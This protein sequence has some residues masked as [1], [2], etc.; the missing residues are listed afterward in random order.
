[1]QKSGA[2]ADSQPAK[3]DLEP[4]RDGEIEFVCDI[5]LGPKA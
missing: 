5:D 4:W 2:S 3:T 1:V